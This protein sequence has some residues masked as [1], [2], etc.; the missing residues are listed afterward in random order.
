MEE[1]PNDLLFD[2]LLKANSTARF[3]EVRDMCNKPFDLSSLLSSFS[4]R[5]EDLLEVYNAHTSSH[6]VSSY[7]HYDDVVSLSSTTKSNASHRW[8]VL[9]DEF[10][11]VDEDCQ[12]HKQAQ[13]H[14]VQKDIGLL[15]FFQWMSFTEDNEVGQASTAITLKD[16]DEEKEEFHEDEEKDTVRAFDIAEFKVDNIIKVEDQEV[17]TLLEETNPLLCIPTF[18]S[19]FVNNKYYV[20][21]ND[22]QHL[23]D[24]RE[25]YCL[26]MLARWG[27]LNTGFIDYTPCQL[28]LL[29]TDTENFIGKRDAGVLC[30]NL[31]LQYESHGLPSEEQISEIQLRLG[32]ENMGIDDASYREPVETRPG[33]S[34]DLYKETILEEDENPQVKTLYTFQL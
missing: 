12:W 34:I 8:R 4:S 10:K 28:A 15:L 2:F 1:T 21:L 20:L 22:I 24:L 9:S 14:L 18:P 5:L 7:V 19:Y 23:F 16:V 30:T 31:C 25:D 27:E 32:I 6:A 13:C 29:D 17:G 11:S 33:Y 26:A 3:T